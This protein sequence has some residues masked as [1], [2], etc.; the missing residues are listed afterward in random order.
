MYTVAGYGAMMADKVRMRAYRDALAAVIRPTSVVV[1]IGAGT[2]IMSLLA[3][4]LGARRV[5]AIEPDDAIELAREA[6]RANGFAHRMECIQEVSTRVTLPE[7]ADVIVSDLRGVLP[8]FGRHLPAIIDARAR[9]L[10]PDGI[11]VPQS[12]RLMAALIETPGVYSKLT[13]LW[14]A[15]EWQLDLTSARPTV[16]SGWQKERFAADQLLTAPFCWASLEYANCASPHVSGVVQTTVER[17][18][19]AHGLAV[20]FDTVLADG[21]GFSNAPG[22]PDLI[23]ALGFFPLERAVPVEAGDE[24][25]AAFSARLVDDDYIWSWET[26]IT[27]ASGD[28]KARY[29]QSTFLGAPLT[30]STLRK[31][32]ADHVATLGEDGEIDHFILSAMG[33]ES[34]GCTARRLTGAYPHRF[35]NWQDALSRVAD[36]SV[37]YGK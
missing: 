6:A 12:D 11:L 24:V 8:P 30:A 35:Q 1:D 34:L 29:R 2:G 22:G 9:L 21:I 14:D 3:C 27:A 37:K 10:K 16:I 7:P 31:R 19:V 20:W 4:Q 18:G 36:L 23:Y 15:N 32:A 25:H 33:R 26:T 17:A 5:F 13:A 28:L